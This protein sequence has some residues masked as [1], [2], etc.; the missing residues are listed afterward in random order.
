[1][2]KYIKLFICIII[3]LA[4]GG[5]SGI[6]TATSINT[7]FVDLNKPIFNPPNYVFGPVWTVLY[8]LMGVSLYL[9]IQTPK[10][11]ARKR[12]ILIFSI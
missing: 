9:I 1:M 11:Y 7:W 4:I 8:I 10:V 12:A 5:V 6:A 2:K 3:P